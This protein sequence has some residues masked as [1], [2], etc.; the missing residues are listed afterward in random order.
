MATAT[1]ELKAKIDLV[2]PIYPDIN[3]FFIPPQLQ[4][5]LPYPP[6]T[7]ACQ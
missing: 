2:R 7:D 1:G 3:I 4:T 6:C 5:A